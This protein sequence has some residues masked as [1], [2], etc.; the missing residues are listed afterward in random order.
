MFQREIFDAASPSWA[1]LS[2][3]KREKFKRMTK[4]YNERYER[5]ERYDGLRDQRT[6]H[7]VPVHVVQMEFEKRAQAKRDA[8]ERITM[9][10]DNIYNSDELLITTPFCLMSANYFVHE[11][12][13]G[14]YFPAEI[15]VVKFSIK[16]GITYKCHCLINPGPLPMGFAFKAKKYAEHNHNLPQPP[17]ALGETDFNAVLFT[18]TQFL[19]EHK[20]LKNGD[21]FYVFVLE[22]EMEIVDNIL[23][24]LCGTEEMFRQFVLLPVGELF[25]KLRTACEW[26]FD[27]VGEDGQQFTLNTCK[28]ILERD[29]YS[30]CSGIC[31][32]VHE[33]LNEDVNPHCALSKPTRWAYLI[34]AYT[35]EICQIG[36][37]KPVS[38][39]LRG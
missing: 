20:T 5:Y 15:G 36:Y 13:T 17:R 21:K 39:K 1:T 18:I 26:K 38:Y 31:C 6:S 10:V 9:L 19:N 32:K 16:H 8:S 7:G 25:F 12:S 29:M 3:H 27:K 4:T 35:L 30:H 22:E 11:A 14:Q 23:R 2:E 34:L 37:Q 28:L 33:E 24:Q